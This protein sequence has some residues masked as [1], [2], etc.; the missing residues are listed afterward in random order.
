MSFYPGLQSTALRLL[1]TYG[2]ALTLRKRT[3]GA[4]DPAT[5]AAA[6]TEADTSVRGAVFDFPA[7]MVDGTSILRGDRQVILAGGGSVPD[8]GDLLL[9]GETAHNVIS[10]KATAPAGTVVIYE[11]QVRR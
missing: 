8:A 10:V 2:Q 4:Y 9:I 6:V 5:G 3:P 1:T 7:G 11:L